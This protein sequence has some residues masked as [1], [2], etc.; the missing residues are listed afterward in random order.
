MILPRL[1]AAF[2]FSLATAVATGAE[3]FTQTQVLAD[4]E[5]L[6]ESLVDTHYNPFA[7]TPE[8][9]FNAKYEE[10]RRLITAKSYDL[11]STIGLYQQLVSSINN[12]HTEIDFP[13]ASYFEYAEAGGSLFPIEVALENG[14]PL[15]RKNFSDNENIEVGD[16]VLAINGMPINE[17]LALVYPHISAERT[18][19]K[20][21][22]LELFTLPHYYWQV[23]GPVE[24]FEVV[25]KASGETRSH[26]I[27]AVAA[28]E[29]YEYVRDDI[30]N[31][32][33]QLEFYANAAYLNPGN[34]SGDKSVYESFIKESF[35]AVK[36][37]K[38]DNLI[39]DLRNNG[40]GDDSFSDYLVSFIADKPFHWNGGFSLRTSERLKA[41]TR[42]NRDLTNPFWKSVMEHDNG[43]VYPYEFDPHGPQDE[44]KRF[45]GTVYV[46]INRQSH[47]QSA[48]TAAQI[49]DYGWA[50]LVGEETGDT[51]TLYASQFH[52]TLPE[53]GITV[54]ISKGYIIRVNGSEKVEGVK[55]DIFIKDYLLDEEDEI[56]T[57]VW[58]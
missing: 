30:L 28:L 42:A 47:S 45:T 33:M 5:T 53:T 26:Q 24:D 52:Y 15:V 46:L 18:Y 36:A 48:V 17:I 4:L 43:T 39:I 49:Q 13:V 23:F 38:V 50:T 14:K 1:S 54:K 44:S 20:N 41:H 31:A 2:F 27:K 7:Y 29:G 19:F 55:P 32:S 22:K 37:S 35:T 10:L 25:V 12:G 11:K 51:P 16:E 9:E 56:L 3:N 8:A 40:G 21:A 34:F 58:L 57:G 6:H